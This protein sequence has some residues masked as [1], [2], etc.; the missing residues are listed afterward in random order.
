MKIHGWNNPQDRVK[1]IIRFRQ[2]AQNLCDAWFAEIFPHGYRKRIDLCLFGTLTA[3]AGLGAEHIREQWSSFE[4]RVSQLCKR[5][6]IDGNKKRHSSKCKI[7]KVWGQHKS[8][9]EHIHF[10]LLT[11]AEDTIKLIKKLWLEYIPTADRDQQD[12]Q[13][14]EKLS[15]AVKYLADNLDYESTT[16]RQRVSVSIKGVV[17]TVKKRI[18]SVAEKVFSQPLTAEDLQQ[19]KEFYNWIANKKIEQGEMNYDFSAERN[20]IKKKR[21]LNDF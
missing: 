21:G 13:P 17:R 14:M 16:I 8:G 2:N 12:I 9:H 18:V 10:L 15:G 11:D 6:L 20:F 1:K 4:K 7:L 19:L 5:G 3:P